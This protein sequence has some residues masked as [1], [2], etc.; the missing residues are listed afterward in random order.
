ME[1]VGSAGSTRGLCGGHDPNGLTPEEVM[2]RWESHGEKDLKCTDVERLY[3]YA[4]G[5]SLRDFYVSN[6]TRDVR[7]GL[8][9]AEEFLCTG[10]N[11]RRRVPCCV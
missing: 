11:G 6:W 7:A 9:V 2:F 8:F 10:G 3:R 1:S 4:A 5:K